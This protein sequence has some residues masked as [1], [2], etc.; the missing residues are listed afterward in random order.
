MEKAIL[1]I[2]LGLKALKTTPEPALERRRG[3]ARFGIGLATVHIVVVVSVI[4]FNLHRLP[5]LL[6]ALRTISDLQ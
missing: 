1:A 2:V 6:E 3:W 5:K 4:L